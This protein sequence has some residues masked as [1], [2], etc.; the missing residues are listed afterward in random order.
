MGMFSFDE[1]LENGS[2]DSI[3]YI[4]MLRR[5][6]KEHPNQYVKY[7]PYTFFV[8]DLCNALITKLEEEL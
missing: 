7:G 3:D 2:L 5:L 1:Q 8:S 4:I 6:A